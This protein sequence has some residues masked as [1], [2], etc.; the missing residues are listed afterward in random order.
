MTTTLTQK[1]YPALLSSA[2]AV[3]NIPDKGWGIVAVRDIPEMSLI[4]MDK[5]VRVVDTPQKVVMTVK[6][7]SWPEDNH[8]PASL[9]ALFPEENA[10]FNRANKVTVTIPDPRTHAFGDPTGALSIYPIIQLCNHAENAPALNAFLFETPD[11]RFALLVSLTQIPADSEICISYLGDYSFFRKSLVQGLLSSGSKKYIADYRTDIPPPRFLAQFQSSP[12]FDDIMAIRNTHNDMKKLAKFINSFRDIIRS[13]RFQSSMSFA[14]HMY[15]IQ[16]YPIM[17]TMRQ[18]RRPPD[19]FNEMTGALLLEPQ[20]L[21]LF[22]LLAYTKFMNIW[23][24]VSSMSSSPAFRELAEAIQQRFPSIRHIRVGKYILELPSFTL[25][26]KN[27]QDLTA[28]QLHQISR[29]S[30]AGLPATIRHSLGSVH[31][32]ADMRSLIPPTSIRD[33]IQYWHRRMFQRPVP[34]PVDESRAQRSLGHLAKQDLTY[35]DDMQTKHNDENYKKHMKSMKRK[36]AQYWRNKLRDARA[37][38]QQQQY[39][40]ALGQQQQAQR[41]QQYYDAV[42][43]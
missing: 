40:D 17:M 39:S 29:R 1:T 9:Q 42:H 14:K 4:A 37:R 43:M 23:I 34:T 6:W 26:P 13:P 7:K 35:W 31:P 5:I 16:F 22:T 27:R 15:W 36:D 12:W 10:R 11:R 2:C 19:E 21:S 30:Y 24:H 20:H 32:D 18:L 41:G 33:D 28:Q 3:R 38:R 8:V 25:R